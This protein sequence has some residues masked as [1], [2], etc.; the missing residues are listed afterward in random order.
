MIFQIKPKM[1][2]VSSLSP[3]A[4]FKCKRDMWGGEEREEGGG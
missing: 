1:L 2:V 4:S 3:L